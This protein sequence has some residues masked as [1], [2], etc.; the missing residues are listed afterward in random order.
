MDRE[1]TFLLIHICTTLHFIRNFRFHAEQHID[2]QKKRSEA[3][4]TCRASD[5]GGQNEASFRSK[6]LFINSS[7]TTRARAERSVICF[8]F[9]FVEHVTSERAMLSQALVKTSQAR[10]KSSL[11]SF[12]ILCTTRFL[13]VTCTRLIQLKSQPRT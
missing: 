5:S 1:R 2:L 9:R 10:L 13:Q 8:S 3:K 7:T 4:S 12:H 6:L 11:I